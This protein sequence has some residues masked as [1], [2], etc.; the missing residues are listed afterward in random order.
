MAALAMVLCSWW[1]ERKVRGVLGRSG[2]AGSLLI[3]SCIYNMN[4]LG[5]VVWFVWSSG[6]GNNLVGKGKEHRAHASK[7]TDRSSAGIGFSGFGRFLTPLNSKPSNN[8]R[9]F[10]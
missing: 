7:G 3:V 4:N 2:V 5:G 9:F 6:G 10:F 1:W 8:I